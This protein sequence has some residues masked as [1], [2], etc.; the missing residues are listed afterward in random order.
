[1]AKFRNRNNS[2]KKE[3][4]KM[5]KL[6]RPEDN[7]GVWFCSW[8]H[9]LRL[10]D[11][12]AWHI[13]IDSPFWFRPK[14]GSFIMQ[15][16]FGE[17]IITYILKGDWPERRESWELVWL[18]CSKNCQSKLE[19]AFNRHKPPGKEKFFK[20]LPFFVPIVE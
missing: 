10:G 6:K 17:R 1:M 18:G 3:K 20:V 12:P 15:L 8:C 19:A 9:A 5:G 11:Q 16:P 4:A 14:G 7:L 2:S 13:L